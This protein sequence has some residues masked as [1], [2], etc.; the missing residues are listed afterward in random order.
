V[1]VVTL[2]LLLADERRMKTEWHTTSP[3]SRTLMGTPGSHHQATCID[4]VNKDIESARFQL[5]SQQ[6]AGF[7]AIALRSCN[8]HQSV[9][10]R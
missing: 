9:I 2:L 4:M 1:V 8:F 10:Q 7:T 5:G 6:P 3:L